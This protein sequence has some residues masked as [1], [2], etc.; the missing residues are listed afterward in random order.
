MKDRVTLLLNFICSTKGRFEFLEKNTPN[1]AKVIGKWPCI[2]NFDI[3]NEYTEKVRK[4]YESNFQNL[5]FE[6]EVGTLW[7]DWMIEKLEN[8]ETPYVLYPIEDVEFFDI[9]TH[10]ILNQMLIDMKKFDVKHLLFGKV[11]K[12]RDILLKG[13]GNKDTEARHFWYHESSNSPYQQNS[14][15]ISALFE[16]DFLLAKVKEVK[17]NK[18]TVK[19]LDNFERLGIK[20]QKINSAIPNKVYIGVPK[21]NP[22]MERRRG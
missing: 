7:C 8:I 21:N 18:N 3:E 19:V 14:L 13:R 10:K 20:G 16:R 9:F 17:P 5:I 4:L 22:P 11:Q 1:V 15:T 6:N 12:Y 2:V